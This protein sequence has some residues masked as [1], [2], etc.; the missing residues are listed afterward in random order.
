MGL[1]HS[2]PFRKSYHSIYGTAE[3]HLPFYDGTFSAASKEAIQ[4]LQCVL[5][6]L[7]SIDH[8]NTAEFCKTVLTNNELIEFVREK[9]V[10]V[11]AGSVDE[12]E[13][14]KVANSISASMYPCI[15]FLSPRQRKLVVM[16]KYEGLISPEKLIDEISTLQARAGAIIAQEQQ[17]IKEVD[18][19]RNIRKQQDEA[20]LASLR[21]DQEKV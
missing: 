6:V 8:P 3:P 21:A 15:A 12:K 16:N 20:Y 18:M 11:W 7:V 5:L 14:F 2:E 10:L 17:Q 1:E 13:A 19:G 9:N 4:R